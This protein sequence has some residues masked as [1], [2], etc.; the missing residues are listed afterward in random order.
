[1]RTTLT[2]PWDRGDLARQAAVD[3]AVNG[4]TRVDTQLVPYG[5]TFQRW[6]VNAELP[7]EQPR[8][9]YMPGPPEPNA[10]FAVLVGDGHGFAE[11]RVQAVDQ[12]DAKRQAKLL[13][14]DGCPG[15]NLR[16]ENL[17]AEVVSA[18]EDDPD[19]TENWRG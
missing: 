18:R 14:I 10:N 19:G 7:V 12:H 6:E 8:I 11:Y 17:S 1:M 2:F 5:G 3:L 15:L 13:F 9:V 16:P 4:C